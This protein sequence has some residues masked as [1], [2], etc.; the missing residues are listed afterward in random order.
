MY[1]D[2]YRY[3]S[4]I[5]MFANTYGKYKNCECGLVVPRDDGKKL[6]PIPLTQ[7]SA[8]VSW[9]DVGIKVTLTQTYKN[10]ETK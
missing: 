4:E 7:V 5:K 8:D 1:F 2:A 3:Y 9:L 6:D 10:K